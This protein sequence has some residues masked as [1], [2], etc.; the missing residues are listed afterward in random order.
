M[1]TQIEP[2]K[3]V[4]SIADLRKL[5]D[6]I[7]GFLGRREG[8]YLFKLAKL[9]ANRGVVVE[10]GSWKGKS[11]VWLAKGAEAVNGQVIYAI[12]PHI[13]SPEHQRQNPGEVNTEQE[14]RA[15][16][17]R[18]GVAN[19]V[20]PLLMTSAAAL[21]GWTKP[22]GLLWIDGDHSYD[23]VSQDYYG[24]LPHVVDG[25]I[26]AFHDTYS[27]EGVRRLVDEEV[28][29]SKQMR[30]LGQLDGILAIQK[31]PGITLTDRL[32]LFLIRRLRKVFNRARSQRKPWRALP[33]KLL[34]A[35]ARPRH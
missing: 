6:Q 34:R 31:S 3:G 20:T 8:V 5:S 27:W 15:N 24:W 28:L 16:I 35:L 23:A 4:G 14:F 30:V 17:G 25:G 13:G 22:I 1:S 19:R 11:T 12:D 10:I 32:N 26:I 9:A 18:A 7:D 2:P 21:A 33:R 29:L